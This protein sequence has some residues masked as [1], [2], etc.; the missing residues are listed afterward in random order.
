MALKEELVGVWQYD[1]YL[2]MVDALTDDNQKKLLSFLDN[3]DLT[4][5]VIA[6][7]EIGQSENETVK[8]MANEIFNALANKTD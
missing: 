7:T 4:D 5:F 8:Q 1:N 6:L 3:E 2:S